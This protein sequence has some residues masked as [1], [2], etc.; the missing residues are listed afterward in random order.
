MDRNQHLKNALERKEPFDILIIG[1][2]ATGVGAAVDAASRGH[3]VLLLEGTDFGKGTSSRSTKLVHGGVRYLQKGDIPLVMD[4]L[5]ERG[6]MRQNA[7]HLVSD[8]AFVVPNYTW[9]EAPFYGIGMKVYDALAGKYGFGKS[10]LLSSEETV[11]KIPT[12]T[13]N[14]LR[15]GVL[16]YD[17]Q[18]DDAR[19]LVNMAQTAADQ[20]ATL[21]NYMNVTGLVQNAEGFTE[22]VQAEDRETGV[23]HK[24]MARVVLN[25]TGPFTDAV[26]QMDDPE[27][28]PVIAPSTGVHIVLPAEFLPRQTAIM[29]P[30]TTDGRVLFAI[31]WHHC[32]VVGTTDTPVDEVSLEPRPTRE[33]VDFILENAR[34]YL[35]KPPE[36]GDV[37]SVFSGIRPLVKAAGADNTAQ[38]SRDHTILVS[39]SGLI[40]IAG[41]KWTTYRHMAEDV[42]DRAE[43]LGGLE[44]RDCVTK[45]LN[46]HGYH[47]H[48]EQFGDLTHYGSDALEVKKLIEAEPELIHEKLKLH[49]GEVRWMARHEMARTVDDV[50]SR[51]S[52]SLLFHAKASRESARRV[53][54]I[55]KEELGKDESW[56]E[57]QCQEF[58]EMSRAYLAEELLA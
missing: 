23:T 21:L 39:Q 42:I 46:I 4:A 53:A 32:V 31:P 3:S 50:L 58:G 20:G 7:P 17:G 43:T 29:V 47:E 30:R 25:C 13:T 8:L 56:V 41:G 15:G 37:L 12:I 24:F 28:K 5:K 54:E 38:L 44:S 52:R 2:G 27:S 51:R 48:A 9:W 36:I 26:R 19:M 55:L 40:S 18:F 35:E 14:G 33:E 49:C 22:G 6:I 57:R 45:R 11:E 34:Q 16:Y 1:G 10:R